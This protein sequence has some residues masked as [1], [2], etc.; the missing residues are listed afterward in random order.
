MSDIEKV[1]D[2]LTRGVESILPSK[3]G[4]AGLMKKRKIR[5]YQGFDPTN[6]SLHIGHFVGARK[7]AQFQKLGHKVIFLIG[8]FTARIGDPTDK[9]AAR[10]QLTRKQVLK[11][12]KDY[13]VQIER[14]VD[15]KGSNPAEI[16]FNSEWLDKLDFEDVIELATNFTVQQMLERDFFQK[17]LKERKPIYLHEFLYPLMQGYDS[18]AMGVDLEI[19]GNDQLFNMLAGRTLLKS[20]KNKEKYVLTTKLLGTAMGKKMSKTNSGAINLNDTDINIFGKIMALSDNFIDSGIVLLTDLPLDYSNDKNPLDV[21]KRIAFEVVKQIRGEKGA[22]KAQEHFENTF[23]KRAAGY[24][25]FVKSGK[26]LSETVAKASG[27]SL[28]QAKRLI[29]Q[30]SVDINDETITDPTHIPAKGDRLKI[31]KKKFVKI[32]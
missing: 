29:S 14:V 17:R 32:K 2:A 26:N 7:L 28:T 24:E 21:K 31:G 27:V 8:D 3:E 12:L 25:D 10:K 19:G 13:K 20:L 30:G 9:T 11:N 6:S 4:L 5:A 16:K 1:N 18:L 22:I 23:Q 15:F